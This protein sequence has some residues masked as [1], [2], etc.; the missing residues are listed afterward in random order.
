MSL[1]VARASIV[2]GGLLGAAAVAAGAFGAHGLKAMLTASGQAE[3]WETACRYALFHAVALVLTGLVASAA[4]AARSGRTL[5]GA[6]WCFAVGTLVF[7]G[8][9]GVL[10]LTGFRL[11]GAV[12]PVGGSLLIAGWLLLA[13]G[14]ARLGDDSGSSAGH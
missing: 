3:N 14:G 10:A 11:L 1:G 7:S 8:C 12:V 9:L 2:A 4:G 5:G 13:L 6:A